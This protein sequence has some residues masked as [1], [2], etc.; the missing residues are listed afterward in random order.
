LPIPR[1]NPVINVL[2]TTTLLKGNHTLTFG[3]TMRHT[4]QWESSWGNAAGGPAFNLGVAAGDPAASITN[5]IPGL[6]SADVLRAQTLYGFLVGRIASITGTHNVDEDS[7]QYG[8]N[9]VIRREAQTVG[10]VYAQDS[11][12]LTPQ[13]TMNYGLR[14]ELSGAMRN[15]NDIYTSP[16]FDHILGPSAALFQPGTLGGVPDP[17]V[18]QQSSPY[19]A[20]LDNLAPNVGISWNPDPEGGVFERLLGKQKSVIRGSVGLNYYDEGLIT[21]QTAA[22]SNVGLTQ[23][24]SLTP[25]MPG[26]EP[27]GLMLTSPIPPLAAFPAAFQFPVSQSLFTFSQGFTAVDPELETPS[28]LNWN[29]GIQR[30]IWQNA[31]FEVRYVGN[32]GRNLWRNYDLN[33]VNV[34]ENGFVNEFR[35]AQQNLQ[36]NRANGLQGFANNN[37]PGQAPLPIFDAAFGARGSQPALPAGSAYTNQQFVTLLNEGQAGRVANTMASNSIYLCRM[38]GS[39]FAPCATLGFDAPGAYPINFF[40]ANPFAAGTNAGN[41]ARVLTDESYSRYHGLQLQFRQRFTGG[42]NMAANYTYS[43]AITDRYTDSPGLTVNYFTLRDKK[44]NEGPTPFDLRHSFQTY[45]TYELP[46]GRNRAVGITNPVLEQIAG[47]WDVS[48]VLRLQSGRPF[49]LTSD[50]WTLNQRDAGVVLNGIGVKELQKRVTV[51][52]GANGN[53]FFLD[54]SLIGPDG[55]ANP[56]F[57]SS[58]TTPGELGELVF[59][60]GP[61]AFAVDLGVAKRFALPGG[62]SFTLEGLFLNALNHPDYLVGPAGFFDD[63]APISINSTTFGQTTA[64]ARDPR[65]IQIRLHVSF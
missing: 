31:A 55:R 26:F 7:H 20:D 64:V 54:S 15:S 23:A 65:N 16:P 12:R 33:E 3:G 30:E 40:Q 36:I 61:G 24:L 8:A 34:I 35:R 14:W 49:Y 10:G 51:R 39:S 57:V 53:V 60:Y 13:L 17:Q 37:L 58:P 2:N 19:K 27:G 62:A 47:G 43:K 6:R 4:Y 46:F 50:R 22:G 56:Q 5:A 63:G 21:F 11:W 28:I 59:L 52:P 42:L 9:P 18:T 1:N 25:G 45:W 48:G 32:R 38:L 29:I 44:R 41:A